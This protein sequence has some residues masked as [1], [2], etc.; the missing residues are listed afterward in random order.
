MAPYARNAKH[1]M[2][3]Q[4]PPSNLEINCLTLSLAR[5]TQSF[6]PLCAHTLSWQI[7]ASPRPAITLVRDLKEQACEV[8][9]IPLRHRLDGSSPYDV[10]SLLNRN[11]QP[12]RTATLEGGHEL[13][14]GWERLACAE[15]SLPILDIP[16]PS[17]LDTSS[18]FP[19]EGA[20]PLS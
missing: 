10:L 9:S 14:M 15:V 18:H 1:G 5:M 19:R 7:S 12:T 4:E 16:P 3:D 6:D 11:D 17:L 13:V 2:R 20:Q 8:S